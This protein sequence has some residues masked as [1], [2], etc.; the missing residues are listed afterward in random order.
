MTHPTSHHPVVR[1]P[2]T[3]DLISQLVQADDAARAMPPLSDLEKATLEQEL[4][5]EHL[6]YSSK[7]EG[8]T[9]KEPMIE[10]AI[11]ASELPKT[12]E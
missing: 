7:I 3:H 9:L 8:T 10:Q 4:A 12:E 6:Y 1:E 11:H 5:I 2:T